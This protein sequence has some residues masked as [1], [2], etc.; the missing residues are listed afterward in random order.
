MVG[1]G[2]LHVSLRD[3]RV[4]SILVIGRSPCGVAHPKIRE[5]IRRDFFDWSD[6]EEQLRG[7]DACFFCLGVS[8]VGKKQEDYKRVTYD[9]T[10]AAG[11]TLARLNP[12]MTFCYVSGAGTDSSEQGRLMWARVKGKTENDLNAL[13][14]KALA[15]RPGFIKPIKGLK[16]A[17]KVSQVLA[18][19][20]PVLAKFLGEHVCTLEDLGKAMIE[21]SIHGYVKPI[22]ECADITALGTAK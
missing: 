1:E 2:V 22:L 18:L 20:Y 16:R 5:V 11:R 15:F 12:K 9:L 3:P 14:F 4:D 21:V 7:Y 6:A 10:M 17:Y 19:V 8:S 13:P